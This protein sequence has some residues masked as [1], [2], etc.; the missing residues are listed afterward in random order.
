M[1]IT[2]GYKEGGELKHQANQFGVGGEADADATAL[3]GAGLL[4]GEGG[5]GAALGGLADASV[6]QGI[7]RAAWP[8]EPR[9]ISS[10]PPRSISAELN[11]KWRLQWAASRPSS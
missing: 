1:G 6:G 4:G 11:H 8:K 7:C 3:G 9:I 5:L 10:I 2:T